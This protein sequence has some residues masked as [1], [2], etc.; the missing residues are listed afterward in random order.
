MKPE[1]ILEKKEENGRTLYRVKWQA[2]PIKYATWQSKLNLNLFQPLI[3]IYEASVVTKNQSKQFQDE[4]IKIYQKAS[5][6]II[7]NPEIQTS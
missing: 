5:N 2:F 1:K 3:D 4:L 7:E 6:P